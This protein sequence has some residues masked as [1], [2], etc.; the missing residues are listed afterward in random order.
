MY[1][2]NEKFGTGTAVSQSFG[3]SHCKVN[4]ADSEKKTD[5]RANVNTWQCWLG[6]LFGFANQR[7]NRPVFAPFG[8]KVKIN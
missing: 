4:T 5:Y 7:Q 1:G 8:P 2:G 6:T 3:S